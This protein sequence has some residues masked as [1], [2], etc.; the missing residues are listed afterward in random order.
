MA[1]G[2][3]EIWPKKAYLT[4]DI[5]SYLGRLLSACA[6]RSVMHLLSP[7]RLRRGIVALLLALTALTPLLGS[8]AATPAGAAGAGP[9]TGYW[10]V[11]SDGGIF[12]YGG[13][14][15]FG[16]TG[17]IKLNMPIVGMAATPSGHGY[18]LG[19]PPRRARATGWSAPTGRSS[20]SVTP[21]PSG[22]PR[23]SSRWP[24]WLPP[25]PASATGPWAPTGRW[26]AS[27]TPPTSATRPEP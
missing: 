12:S 8:G 18:R 9:S 6:E 10:M 26:P 15:F 2:E 22:R 7:S 24:P 4:T 14:R 16:S 5:P 13:A 11:A 20:P 19:P 17:A 23:R 21:L 1:R 27:A 3:Q 25:R